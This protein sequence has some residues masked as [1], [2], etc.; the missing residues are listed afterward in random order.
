MAGKEIRKGSV[1]DIIE[2]EKDTAIFI[3]MKHTSVSEVVI[4]KN[5]SYATE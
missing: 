5:C 3:R 1:N 4:Y 2:G